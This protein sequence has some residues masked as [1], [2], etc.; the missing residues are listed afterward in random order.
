MSKLVKRKDQ[1]NVKQVHAM[2]LM[3]TTDMTLLEVS[4]TIGV[5]ID[6][7]KHWLYR[8]GPFFDSWSE[9]LMERVRDIEPHINLAIMESISFLRQTLADEDESTSMRMKAATTLLTLLPKRD[10]LRVDVGMTDSR[11]ILDV[12]FDELKGL[13]SST[14]ALAA[15]TGASDAEPLQQASL[16][17]PEVADE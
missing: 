14:A 3:L 17:T 15:S 12:D 1:L 9:K 4:K 6:I 7:L 13:V 10:S 11:S 16:E 8:P 2:E 5:H